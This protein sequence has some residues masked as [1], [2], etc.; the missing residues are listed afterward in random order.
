MVSLST[1]NASNAR[2]ATNLPAGM[3]AV[4]VGATS[5][6]G[7]YTLKAFALQTKNPTIYLIGR[8][9][10]AANRIVAECKGINPGGKY[11][12]IKSDVSL[13]KNV[14]KVCEQILSKENSINLLF[15]TQGTMVLDSEYFKPHYSP[16]F[17]CIDLKFESHLIRNVRRPANR[18][19][20]PSNISN[21]LHHQPPPRPPK[22]EISPTSRFRLRRRL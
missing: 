12:F 3:V 10:P 17:V 20:T 16:C 6:I 22:S 4:F 18:I 11:I 15:Q 7:E 8:S 1:V 19:R 13:L 5:G 9:D 14:D 21:P 2:I